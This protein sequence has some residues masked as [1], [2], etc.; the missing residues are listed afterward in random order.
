MKI[1][2]RLVEITFAFVVVGIV[3][4]LDIIG[5]IQLH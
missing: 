5:I 4:L 1:K 3:I 2:Q